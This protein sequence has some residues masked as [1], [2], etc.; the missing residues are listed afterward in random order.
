MVKIV[1]Y[2]HDYGYMIKERQK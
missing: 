1:V 2:Y